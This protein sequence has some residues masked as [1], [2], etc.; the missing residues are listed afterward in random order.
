MLVLSLDFETTGLNAETDRVI[1]IGAILYS[2]VQKKCLTS[3]GLL[4]KSDVPIKPEVTKVT[5]ITQEAVNRFGY[6][7]E[8][9][10]YVIL[11]MAEDADA[12]IGYN[13]RSFDRLFLENWASRLTNELGGRELPDKPYIDLYY[14]LPWQV[15]VGKLSHLAADHGILNLFPHSALADAQTVLAIAEK[16]DFNFLLK[17]AQSPVIVLRSHQ[18]RNENDIVKQ[19]PWK[20]RWSPKLQWWWKA[21]KEQDV[22]EIIASA[23]F[24]ISI[25]KEILPEEL[26]K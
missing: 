22:D 19:A 25:E 26:I 9:G 14:D 23:P 8:D 24:R 4:V 3:E 15:P 7:S 18:N 21:V 5:G 16:Y 2:S 13:I 10:L 12:F 6:D 1:E 17:R 20:F 11:N